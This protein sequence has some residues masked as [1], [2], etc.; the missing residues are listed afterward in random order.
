MKN[1]LITAAVFLGMCFIYV[2]IML[3][4]TENNFTYIL[5]DA[6]IHL[7]L[8]KNFALHGVWG[9]TEYVYSSSSSSPLFTFLLSGL[10]YVFGNHQ[11]IPLL[12]NFGCV[13]LTVYFLNKYYSNL[14]KGNTGVILASLFTLLFASVHLL[15]FSGMEHV[16]Q[17]LVIVINIYC[18]E[19]WR[20]SGFKNS[21]YS[22]C[23]YGTL[24]LL[25][26]IRFESMFYFL[27]LAFVFLGL[28]KWRQ[29]TILL[30]FGFI[31]IGIFGYFTHQETGYYFP[32]SVIVKG[33]KLDFSG[34]Y[35]VQIKN[36]FLNK[37]VLKPYFHLVALPPLCF[38]ALLLFKDYKNKLSFREIVFRN[39]LLIVFGITLFVQAAF[40]QFTN[41]YRYEAYLLTAFAML[42]IPRI[43]NVFAGGSIVLKQNKTTVL[44]IVCTFMILVLKMVLVSILIITGSRNIYEQQIQSARFLKQ[45]YNNSKLIANDIG[46]VCY[47]TDI[48]LLDIAGLGS[49]EAVP[50]KVKK[51]GMN[52]EFEKFLTA[53]TAQ[54]HFQL[55]IVYEGW[56]E[57]HVPENW[58]KAAVLEI[59]GGNAVLGLKEVTIYSV[60]PDI[61]HSLQQNVKNFHWN[62]NVVVRIIK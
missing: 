60:D 19:K 45:Y 33:T 59:Q 3:S 31:P 5:D 12:F 43:K 55:A 51:H 1:L 24:A 56:L 17:V 61:H 30:M 29:S 22:G 16:L 32:N 44:L 2:L 9:V 28:G 39:F 54:N 53:Y 7:A 40:G 23:F 46:A 4:E 57:G 21:S 62:K 38:V 11:L 50:F 10:I 34:N 48:H 35:L 13:L 41:F 15:V 47:F 36:I 52:D 42:V 20:T 6:Y 26:L 18:F 8:A 37:L 25:G 27:A 49:K 14:F 58:R